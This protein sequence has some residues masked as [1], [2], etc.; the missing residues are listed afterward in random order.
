[1]KRVIIS[2]L[3]I[4]S[5]Y[6]N[7]AALVNFLSSLDC[8]ELILAGDIIDFL[9]VPSFTEKSHAIFELINHFDQKLVYIVGNHDASFR[10]LVGKSAFGVQFVDKY[11][12]VDGRRK[13][14][15][16]HG[17]KYDTGIAKYRFAMKIISVFQDYLERWLN[18]DLA[19]RWHSMAIK[20]RKLRRIWDITQWNDDADVFIM[21]HI[22]TP[23]VLI[24]INDDET[25]KTYAN[26]GDWVEH[27]T[28]IVIEDDV[29]R[30]RNWQLERKRKS[31]HSEEGSGLGTK[32]LTTT[33]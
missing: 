2:D 15:V 29:I 22:H 16:E 5:K 21:G 31:S 14:R 3:H 9:K 17:D 13:Y 20:K 6:A 4:G 19:T 18:I 24:W 8:D 25:I 11:E 1:M 23:E 33:A 27:Q 7:E 30:L 28:Y 10:G 32:R 26:T 12:F